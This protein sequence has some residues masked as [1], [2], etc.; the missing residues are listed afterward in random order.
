LELNSL[1]FPFLSLPF[2]ACLSLLSY[3]RFLHPSLS[4]PLIHHYLRAFSENG[5]DGD[6][7][8]FNAGVHF[9]GSRVYRIVAE[10]DVAELEQLLNCNC[11]GNGS[12]SLP[13]PS[14]GNM[15]VDVKTRD[16]GRQLLINGNLNTSALETEQE[17]YARV[18]AQKILSAQRRH[19]ESATSDA[20]GNGNDKGNGSG[21]GDGESNHEREEVLVLPSMCGVPLL[22]IAVAYR[23]LAMVEFLLINGADPCARDECGHTALFEAFTQRQSPE[24]VCD[25]IC[26]VCVIE[27]FVVLRRMRSH[28]PGQSYHAATVAGTGIGSS[29]FVN[30]VLIDFLHGPRSNMRR[31][32][33]NQIIQYKASI[34]PLS[35]YITTTTRRHFS[36]RFSLKPWRFTC[37][38][39]GREVIHCYYCLLYTA[40][41]NVSSD[42]PLCFFVGLIIYP[43]LLPISFLEGEPRTPA[44]RSISD[45]SNSLSVSLEIIERDIGKTVDRCVVLLFCHFV[46]VAFIAFPRFD[47]VLIALHRIFYRILSHLPLSSVFFTHSTASH[48][49]LTLFFFA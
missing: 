12:K 23:Q 44:P 14:V 24:Q 45:D 1:V 41:T 15:R 9:V 34:P 17:Q 42:I 30:C 29:C 11:N 20:N 32:S 22:H 5:S 37:A 38:A 26:C 6:L 25:A 2:I 18:P 4:S 33:I 7:S 21:D 27:C 28:C 36:S 48:R 46:V 40:I 35:P 39:L 49:I 10:G 8:L 19:K 3:Q 13:R 16:S 47:R 43:S 31:V